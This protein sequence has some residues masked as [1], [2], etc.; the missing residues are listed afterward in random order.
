MTDIF[1]L[2]NLKELVRAQR[3]AA[4]ILVD[5]NVVIE[6]E[7]FSKWQTDLHDPI[8][9]LPWSIIAELARLKD[10]KNEA[11]KAKARKAI[12]AFLWLSGQGGSRKGISVTNIGWLITLKVPPR[13]VLEPELRNLQTIREIS[14]D[15]DTTFMLLLIGLSKSFPNT[16]V[17][18]LSGDKILTFFA[19]DVGLLAY[20]SR[21]FPLQLAGWIEK[22]R[23]KVA[24][25][26]DK[27]LEE[28]IRR[29]E[30][31]AISA[32]LTLTTKRVDNDY[33]FESSEGIS[34]RGAIIAEGNGIIHHPERGNI[35]FTWRLP[36]KPWTS[37]ILAT[38]PSTGEPD[39]YNNEPTN[40]GIWHPPMLDFLGREMEVPSPL[41]LAIGGKIVEFSIPPD[42]GRGIPASSPTLQSPV[43]TAEYLMRWQLRFGAW[44]SGKHFGS[45]TESPEE[46]NIGF[47]ESLDIAMIDPY[48][49]DSYE[50]L[51]QYCVGY[52]SKSAERDKYE[53]LSDILS[54]WNVGHTVNVIL[55]PE[56]ISEWEESLSQE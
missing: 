25:D 49:F 28:A 11:T 33:E 55:P 51:L 3:P 27:E 32:E 56:Y 44:L 7:D 50:D 5:T 4:I 46:D 45:N 34:R 23:P 40:A 26:L 37:K 14:Y 2:S 20:C 22:K 6:N 13:D 30:K 47:L 54:I 16:P 15:T 43:C 38:D 48:A 21:S 31:N 41:A 52:L 8:F 17:M 10:K 12:D 1:D 39:L 19:Q 35:N 42:A 9:V 18:L 29:L 36:Y 24:I 53:F